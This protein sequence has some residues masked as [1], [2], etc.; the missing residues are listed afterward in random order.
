MLNMAVR[1]TNKLIREISREK[2][3]RLGRFF[4]KKPIAKS[5][6]SLFSSEGKAAVT[7]LDAGA[8]TG[9]LSAAAVEALAAR[10]GVEKITLVAYE[11]DAVMLPML[12]KNLEQ[13]RVRC[14]RLHHVK[15]TFTIINASFLSEEEL[16]LGVPA[17]YDFIITNPPEE[18]MGGDSAEVKACSS[19]CQGETDL[20][21]LFAYRARKKLAEGGQLV[22]FL[23]TVLAS[24]V[25]LEKIR[26]ALLSGAALTD[27][28]LLKKKGASALEKKMVI[29]IAANRHAE[30]IVIHPLLVSGEEEPAFSV[31][32]ALIVR[33]EEER[34]LLLSGAEDL[35]ILSF[36]EG[37]KNTLA[38]FG[39]RMRTGLTLPSRYAENISPVQKTGTVPLLH[40][41]GIKDGRISF[42]LKDGQDW[43][44]PTLPSL[45]QKNKNLVLIK[46]VPTKADGR[47]IVAAA[48]AAS[49]L[50]RV[51][52]ISTNNK[53][54]YIDFP[55]GR[56]MSMP[57]VL[58]LTAVLSSSLYERY[59]CLLNDRRQ[60]NA[61]DYAALPLPDEKTICE[62]GAQ[63]SLLR[64]FTR[65]AI[66]ATVTSHFRRKNALS[67]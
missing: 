61:S 48:Y 5:M 30:D 4:T 3:T 33:G 67:R 12:E 34:L 42:P 17:E 60:I 54:N 13:L 52:Y 26:H 31:P 36:V 16:P 65:K 15:L 32:R 40:P 6:A 53:L 55:D 21:F 11:T 43:L 29:K 8:G 58:G 57:F 50:P 24:G 19:V 20:A 66:D 10:S 18:L 49:Q 35:S 1:N 25:Y 46:R 22:A 38:T 59:I 56:E 23:P 62:I 27:L 63:M 44:L 45:K 14:R 47:H 2:N 9:I 37:Q 41:R 64:Q 7:L 39:L 51:P 28:C